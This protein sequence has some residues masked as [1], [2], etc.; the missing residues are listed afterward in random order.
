[1]DISKPEFTVLSPVLPTKPATDRYYWAQLD[2]YEDSSKGKLIGQH[3]QLMLADFS[4]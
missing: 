3:Y 4:G 1:M 2:I